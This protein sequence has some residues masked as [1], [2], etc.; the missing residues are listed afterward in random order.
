MYI[1]GV[2]HKSL[3]DGFIRV[4]FH[5]KAHGKASGADFI[6]DDLESAAGVGT[7]IKH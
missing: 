7:V 4:L 5:K 6:T 1:P 3:N 2:M